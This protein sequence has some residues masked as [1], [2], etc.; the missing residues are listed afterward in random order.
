MTATRRGCS[1]QQKGKGSSPSAII[2]PPEEG[3]GP[4]PQFM[5]HIS[6]TEVTS[7]GPQA[8]DG[9]VFDGQEN[10]TLREL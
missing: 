8:N 7:Q 2:A 9:Q 4:W 1:L 3:P 6:V 5:Q 10:Y